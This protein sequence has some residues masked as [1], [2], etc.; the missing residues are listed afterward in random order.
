VTEMIVE[1]RELDRPSE[2][3]GAAKSV[4]DLPDVLLIRFARSV[5]EQ[6]ERP[7]TP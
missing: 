3:S 5:R 6:F 1:V 2:I 4:H 7:D